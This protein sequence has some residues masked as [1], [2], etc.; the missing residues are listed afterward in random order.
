MSALLRTPPGLVALAR[1]FTVTRPK[2]HATANRPSPR[3]KAHPEGKQPWYGVSTCAKL[4][5]G[6]I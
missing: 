2:M 5:A 1:P 6:G 4:H 3:L